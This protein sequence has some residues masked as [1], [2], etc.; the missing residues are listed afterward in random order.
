M[1][2]EN[3]RRRRA[4]RICRAATGG[5]ESSSYPERAPSA[6]PDDPALATWLGT[7]SLGTFERDVVMS[8]ARWARRSVE[9][10]GL[11]L[12]DS[13]ESGNK[14]ILSEHAVRLSAL[15]ALTQHDAFATVE[16]EALSAHSEKRSDLKLRAR[17]A[18]D[19]RA[20]LEFKIYQRNDYKTV[21][22][23]AIGYAI[24]SDTFTAVITVDRT[25]KTVEDYVANCFE[26]AKPL[27]SERAPPG[28]EQPMLLT[29]HA[30]SNAGSIRVWHFLLRLPTA[31]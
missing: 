31:T 27:R 13:A 28:V 25:G 26:D 22:R 5:F 18:S 12:K 21:V 29:E 9:F 24:P 16:A 17:D 4:Q 23:Q 7:Y 11:V 8:L 14:G 3:A 10:P 15:M 6:A 30:R 2:V 20:C 1:P 19:T